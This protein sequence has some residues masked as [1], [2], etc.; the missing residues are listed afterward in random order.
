METIKVNQEFRVA[1][2]N[3]FKKY[4]L[5]VCV[6]LFS[7]FLPLQIM[8]EIKVD[9]TAEQRNQIARWLTQSLGTTI[10]VGADGTMSIAN[11]GNASA[12]RLRNMINDGATSVTLKIVDNDPRV[13][14]GGWQGSDP[15]N[16]KST[17][18]GTQLIDINDIK[19]FGN[20]LNSYGF[21]PDSK[22]M[23]EITEVYEGKKGGLNYED[24]HAKGCDAEK[25]LMAVHNT[26][27]VGPRYFR[28][29]HMKIRRPDGSYVIVRKKNRYQRDEEIEWFRER[30]PCNTDSGFIAIP[31]P[32]PQ[33]HIFKYDF[34]LKHKIVSTIDKEN[35]SPTGVA[36]NAG[37]NLYV[38]EN[39]DGVGEIRVFNV[40]NELLRTIKGEELVS[41]QGI[42]IDKTTGEIFVAVKG[43]VIKYSK[44]AEYLGDYR[45]EGQEFQPTDVA[46]W[47]N[48]PIEGI[49]G[50]GD[51]YDIYVTDRKSGQV[52]QFDVVKNINS[53]EYKNAFGEGLLYKP[54]G[55]HI[56]S[57]WSVWVA[58]TGNNRIYRFTPT[59]ELE[60]FGDRN[61]F[62]EDT[63]RVFFDA[64]MVDFDGIYVIDGTR[65]KGELL[66]YDFEGKLINSYGSGV[67]QC[68]TSL[69]INFL[70]D[71]GNMVSI[72]DPGENGGLGEREFPLPVL[73]AIAALIILAII[74]YARRNRR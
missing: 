2:A 48:N 30:I 61:Y 5:T 50:E 36:F 51:V 33:V 64:A 4:L 7:S 47:R 40:N 18:N 23:H 38:L 14:V 63:G 74:Y 9:G 6:L 69:A 31:D 22:L 29:G 24:A 26:S 43:R 57:W 66:L 17:T 19:N 8:S 54:E 52:F 41:P 39:L 53:G 71:F 16:P 46:V 58:S 13:S 15:A 67:L 37:G 68:P 55:L 25:E 1:N 62:V 35:S 42:E 65:N 60:P 3:S 49:F 20:V 11:G 10:S 70:V 28:P 32:D 59:G 44:N 73:L 12:T 72:P 21:T 27:W 34:E 45:I 56:D